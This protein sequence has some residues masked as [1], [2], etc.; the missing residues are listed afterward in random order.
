MHGILVYA[1]TEP[2]PDKEKSAERPTSVA[3]SVEL[4]GEPTAI[5]Q[6]VESLALA[7]R[8]AGVAAHRAAEKPTER[9]TSFAK[10]LDPAGQIANFAKNLPRLVQDFE[11]VHGEKSAAVRA[12]I[13]AYGPANDVHLKPPDGPGPHRRTHQPQPPSRQPAQS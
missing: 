1:V 7:Y 13:P 8:N 2:T 12:N 11:S 9:T 3:K 5:G 10:T 4:S 6:N